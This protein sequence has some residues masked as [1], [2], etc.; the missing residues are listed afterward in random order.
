M[1]AVA[2]LALLAAALIH[3]GLATGVLHLAPALTILA[4]LF[5]GRYV[6]EGTIARIAGHRERRAPR[7]AH[8]APQL[9][10]LA[11]ALARG[12]DL[13]GAALAVRPPPAALV[14]R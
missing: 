7:T 1:I 5:L 4:L 8:V 11:R 14:V 10:P 3:P 6:G 13:L 2:A 9:R 12:G